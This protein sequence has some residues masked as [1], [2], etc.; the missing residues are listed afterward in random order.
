MLACALHVVLFRLIILDMIMRAERGRSLE[1]F[2][3]SSVP[4]VLPLLE[5]SCFE[6]CLVN[7]GIKVLAINEPTLF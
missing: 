2:S 3:F 7:L 5:K 6:L 1:H 4:F